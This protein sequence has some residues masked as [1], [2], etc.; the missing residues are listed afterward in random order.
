MCRLFAHLGVVA[1]EPGADWMRG[2]S[3]MQQSFSETM[4]V[5]ECRN[6]GNRCWDTE[7]LEEGDGNLV[8]VCPLCETPEGGEFVM[9][10][11]D[12]FPFNPF[13]FEPPERLPV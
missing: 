6:C 13:S 4:Y 5:Y 1:W 10:I 8:Y 9:Q 12:E 7:N 2:T 3:V 11:V